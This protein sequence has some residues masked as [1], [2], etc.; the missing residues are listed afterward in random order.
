MKTPSRKEKEEL[1]KS[2]TKELQGLW[3]NPI[4]TDANFDFSDWKDEDLERKTKENISL[5][6]HAKRPQRIALVVMLV[7][8]PV[9]VLVT[10]GF[11]LGIAGLLLFG[12]KQLF[13]LF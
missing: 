1:Y 2:K 11:W 3:K 12:I 9:V 8:V 5:I 4:P 6:R 7:F 13:A 10:V